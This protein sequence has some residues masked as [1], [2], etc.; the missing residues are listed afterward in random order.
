MRDTL[1]DSRQA[2]RITVNPSLRRAAGTLAIDCPHH[3]GL[4][5]PAVDI[6]IELPTLNTETFGH[7][8]RVG[9]AA[10]QIKCANRRVAHRCRELATELLAHAEALDAHTEE[11]IEAS[12]ASE[13]I[14]LPRTKMTP[15]QAARALY[16]IVCRA[17]VEQGHDIGIEVSLCDPDES[18]RRSGWNCWQVQWEAGPH[19]WAVQACGGLDPIGIHGS[20]DLTNDRAGFFA[21]PGYS[22]SV[23]FY[24][25]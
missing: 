25:S 12:L 3:A 8:Y 13:S 17:A 24:D 6:S 5:G 9:E 18:I 19:D 22:F 16:A 10:E 14:D 1:Y 7:H 15:E 20:I 23:C 11:M 4:G 2:L 21:E